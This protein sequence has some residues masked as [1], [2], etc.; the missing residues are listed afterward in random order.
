MAAA[1]PTT[2]PPISPPYPA[3][4][5][6]DVAAVAEAEVLEGALVDD[7]LLDEVEDGAA[8]ATWLGTSLPQLGQ[9]LEPGV[10]CRQSAN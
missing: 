6:V 5:F 8:W 4:A 2:T 1:M 9:F 10:F 3:A 7:E